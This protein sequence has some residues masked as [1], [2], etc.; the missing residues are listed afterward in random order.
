MTGW[1]FVQKVKAQKLTHHTH[2]AL[3]HNGVVQHI[4]RTVGAGHH[5]FMTS[6][7]KRFRTQ[8]RLVL[9]TTYRKMPGS[10]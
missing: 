6:I 2:P 4:L 9:A 5:L 1:V 8:Y 3:S 7:N 10:C